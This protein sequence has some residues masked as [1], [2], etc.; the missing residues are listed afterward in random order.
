M[1]AIIAA[2]V[3]K[4][5]AFRLSVVTSLLPALV[6]CMFDPFG[7]EAIINTRTTLVSKNSAR[8]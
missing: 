2:N 5:R 6:I 1:P 8:Q 4:L 3:V 7:I